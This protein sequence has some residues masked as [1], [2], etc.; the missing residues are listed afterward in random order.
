MIKRNRRE[1]MT[2][3]ENKEPSKRSDLLKA[4]RNGGKTLREQHMEKEKKVLQD[5]HE[6]M[7]MEEE[8]KN[9]KRKKSDPVPVKQNKKQ[10]LRTFE[11]STFK[12][13]MSMWLWHIKMAGTL[14]VSIH[15]QKVRT[16]RL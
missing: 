5:I 14:V 12:I 11:S 6:N 1:M 16:R 2:W 8:Q 15:F 3:L 7:L 10:R 13:S 9:K 4:A